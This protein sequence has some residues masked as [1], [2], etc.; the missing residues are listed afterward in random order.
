MLPVCQL[1]E[2]HRS[3]D[4]EF[5]RQSHPP[6]VKACSHTLVVS[7]RLQVEGGLKA[8]A[9]EQGPAASVARL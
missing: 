2:S 4:N 3:A 1:S 7:H 9:L 5:S 8:G 6:H